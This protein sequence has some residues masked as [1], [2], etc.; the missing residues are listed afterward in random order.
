MKGSAFK[1]K[2][3]KK[4]KIFS[5]AWTFIITVLQKNVNITLNKYIFKWN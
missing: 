3:K 5:A 1:K 2:K 4:S